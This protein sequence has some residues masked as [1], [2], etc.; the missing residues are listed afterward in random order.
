MINLI[1]CFRY[2]KVSS[3]NNIQSNSPAISFAGKPRLTKDVFEKTGEAE[4][5]LINNSIEINTEDFIKTLKDYVHK[6]KLEYKHYEEVLQEVAASSEDFFTRFDTPEIIKAR[7]DLAK[8][9]LTHLINTPE[10]NILRENIA[11]ILYDKGSEKKE[12]QVFIIMGPPTSGKSTALSEPLAKKKGAMIIDPD[13]AKEHIPEYAGGKFAAAVHEESWIITH[14]V[15]DKAI[16]N[17]DNIV[18]PIVGSYPEEILEICN[19]F[20]SADYKIHLRLLDVSPE[21]AAERAVKRYDKTGRFVDPYYI[22]NEVGILP[23]ENFYKLIHERYFDTHAFLSNEV[24]KG[25]PPILIEKSK[26]L[27]NPLE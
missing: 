23:R 9:P 15:L 1:D 19:K 11:N 5:T 8:A 2:K 16:E 18:L 20:D 21:V 17:N 3:L 25:E 7:E 14:N 24:P 13:M 10:R 27:P 6:S 4:K 26:N 22:Y 12:K